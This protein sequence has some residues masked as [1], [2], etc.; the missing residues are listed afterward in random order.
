MGNSSSSAKVGVA[1]K[2]AGSLPAEVADEVAVSPH[3]D[4]SSKF[5]ERMRRI[6]A[7]RPKHTFRPGHSFSPDAYSLVHMGA[8]LEPWLTE[9]DKLSWPQRQSAFECV[10]LA[11][12]CAHEI[13]TTLYTSSLKSSAHAPV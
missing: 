9:F 13:R 1:V 5:D 10:Q 2:L 11:H 7:D 4:S 8:K 6:L 12:T 3:A